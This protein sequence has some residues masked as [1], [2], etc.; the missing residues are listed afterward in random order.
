M[1]QYSSEAYIGLDVSKLRNA[2]AVAEGGRNGEVNRA[3]I[4][5]G[6]HS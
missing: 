2:V 5:G 3:G 4:V 6:F 1:E